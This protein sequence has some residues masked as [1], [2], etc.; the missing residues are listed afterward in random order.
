MSQVSVVRENAI[1]PFTAGPDLTGLEGYPVEIDEN[2]YTI[3]HCED[4]TAST[5][6]CVLVKGG[7]AGEQRVGQADDIR[8]AHVIE[9]G[10]QLLPLLLKAAGF[11]V[12]HLERH[13]PV[14]A[15]RGHVTVPG[16]PSQEPGRVQEPVEEGGR[17][18]KECALLLQVNV[19]S[20]EEHGDLLQPW[21]G[22][23]I[24]DEWQ[25]HGRDRDVV[26]PVR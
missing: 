24:E 8:F 17:V 16:G 12:E 5:P 10:E 3:K 25:V 15:C 23:V 1:V 18:A 9:P 13:L 22:G 14:L 4:P 19:D 2:D 26:I 20:A 6:I 21:Q 7:K 11:H